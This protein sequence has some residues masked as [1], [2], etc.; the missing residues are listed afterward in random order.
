MA[1][2]PDRRGSDE[3]YEDCRGGQMFLGALEHLR[4]K[5]NKPSA[6]VTA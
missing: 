6:Q 3:D 4:N 5:N 1:A 2:A